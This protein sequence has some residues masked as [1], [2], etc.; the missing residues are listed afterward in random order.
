M[1]LGVTIIM[2]SSQPNKKN[3]LAWW[4][5]WRADSSSLRMCEAQPR[6]WMKEYHFSKK[7][8]ELFRFGGCY[9][10]VMCG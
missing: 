7:C 2:P 1:P 3:P 4:S 8:L 9:G 10:G 6:Q 5:E